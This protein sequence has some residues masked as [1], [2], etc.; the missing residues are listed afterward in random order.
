[1]VKRLW[2]VAAV[3]A[4]LVSQAARHNNLG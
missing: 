4:L 1:M 3:M 2:R